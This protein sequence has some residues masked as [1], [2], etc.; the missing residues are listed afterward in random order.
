MTPKLGASVAGGRTSFAVRAP[1]ADQL[2][3]CLFDAKEREQSFPMARG[4]D[5]VWHLDLAEDLAG[6]RYGYRASGAWAPDRGLWYDPAKLLVDPYAVELDRR[7]AY[8]PS[9]GAHG[10]ETAAL[11]PR[12]IV[13]GA[14]SEVPRERPL[15]SP[16]GL[17]YEV[18]VRGFT[19]LHPDVPEALR[20]TVAALAHPAIIAHL[21]KLRVSA[22]ELMPIVAWIDE[23]HLPPLGLANFWGFHLYL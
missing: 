8:H 17:V 9:L 15:I 12:A 1:L 22:V 3:L 21:Q 11:V 23:R 5:G 6:T 19:L 18:N 2:W 10:L 13:P 20:G 14:M 7:F 16:G 4:E